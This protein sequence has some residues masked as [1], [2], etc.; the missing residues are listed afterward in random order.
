MDRAAL[1]RR[2]ERADRPRLADMARDFGLLAAELERVY[3]EQRPAAQPRA[4]ARRAARG[5]GKGA[6]N[7]LA[8]SSS[9]S[10]V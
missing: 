7:A 9:A 10:I 5:P 1:L 2:S 4:A 6:S 3:G 8:K